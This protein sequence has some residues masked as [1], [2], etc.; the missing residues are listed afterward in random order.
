[1]FMK[2]LLITAGVTVSLLSSSLLPAAGDSMKSLEVVSL[3]ELATASSALP[4][5]KRAP[6][7]TPTSRLCGRCCLTRS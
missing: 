6:K 5:I 1:M 3:G 4:V 7:L 2:V